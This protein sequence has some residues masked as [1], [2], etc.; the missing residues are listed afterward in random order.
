MSDTAVVFLGQK[1]EIRQGKLKS[2]VAN[3]LTL[4]ATFKKKDP[5]ELLGHFAWKQKTLFLFGYLDGKPE[6]ENQHHLPPPLEGCTYFGDILVVAS[7]EANSYTNIVTL[8]TA[9]YE[10][11]YTAKLEGEESE[12]EEEEEA[13]EEIVAEAEEESEAEDYGE[14]EE[15]EVV[16]EEP[17]EKPTRVSRKKIIAAVVEEPE[18]QDTD[19]VESSKARTKVYERITEVFK[20]TLDTAALEA[21]IFKSSFDYAIQHEIRKAWS[22][23]LFQDIYLA[24][25][26]RI[27]GNMNPSSYVKNK[28]LWDRYSSGELTLEQISKQNYYELC[29]EKW[30]EMLDQQVKREHTQLE[31]DFS[32]ATDKWQCNGCKMRK[33][34]YYELQT[35]SADEPMT[36]FIHCL[37]CGKRWT[38]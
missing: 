11:F 21:I 32:R 7:N 15:E 4:T 24:N 5:P 31:G 26:R 14:V 29:P 37:N 23:S 38:R 9:D 35:R 1:G 20:D 34:T 2:S 25:A 13:A 28:N 22:N 3:A 6:T 18:I 8:K 17:I 16:E 19:L 10:M 36:L 30:K 33:C 12:V 27:I